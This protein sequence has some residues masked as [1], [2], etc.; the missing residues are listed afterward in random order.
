MNYPKLTGFVPAAHTPFL[1]DGSLDLG[2][3]EKQAAH[4][5][6]HKVPGVFIMGTT[7]ECH[8]LSLEERLALAARWL[9]VARGTPLQVVVH[10]GSNSLSDARAL[11]AD[12]QKRGAAAIAALA[13]SYYKP[14]DV[15]TLVD[16][17]AEIASAAPQT[18]FY[19]Y[20]IPPMTGVPLP[21]AEFLERASVRLPTLAGLKFSNPD[22]L[23]FQHCL[24]HDRGRFA[25]L[26]GSD[27]SLLA[28]LALGGTG[29]VGS[30]YNFAAPVYH[31]LLKAFHAGDLA[32]AREEQFRSARVVHC[33]CAMP[34]GFLSASRALMGLLGV[35]VGPAR[36]PLA[37]TTPEHIGHLQA[38][39]EEMGFFGW[40]K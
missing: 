34:G 21:M 6:T 19:Y 22:L 15:G 33:L 8:S 5:L 14:R 16:C 27:E 3:V 36:L 28:A 2:G 7:G 29:A 10:V 12:A 31:R 20:D 26:W 9:D 30:T 4:M 1:Q 37:S 40:I 24:H 25:V 18:P 38:R 35:P 17:M 13:P 39:L 32:T 11:A 23:M